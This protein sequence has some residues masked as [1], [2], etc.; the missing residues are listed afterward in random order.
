MNIK[1]GDLV[2]PIV[3]RFF[4]YDFRYGWHGRYKTWED[5]LKETTGYNAEAVLERVRE[6]ALKV[7][8]GEAVYERDAIIY[9]S[10]QV[11]FPLLSTLLW[12]ASQNNNRLSIIDYGGSLGTSYRQNYRFIKHLNHIE[13]KIIEQKVFVDEGRKNFENEHLSFYYD[14]KECLQ[15]FNEQPQ[16][17]MF[18]N[19]L[20]Y[21]QEPYTILNAVVNSGISN[22]L[23]DL[24]P[25][26][27]EPNDRLTIQ[28]VPPVFY[29]A[30]YPAWF[31]SRLKMY[32]FLGKYYE[33]VFDF[34]RGEKI[35]LSF[36]E[37]EYT[38][39][40]WTAKG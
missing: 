8:N 18:S 24:T 39:C 3:K 13:W 6:S 12:V 35:N 19:S 34:N 16:L 21:L 20:A 28:K 36:Q 23:L 25:F 2:P 37:V 27:D 7:K 26:I 11:Q 40:L 9:D 14:L 1:K 15:S 5:A 38:G 4:R 10:V 17:I 30:S 31:F 22:L 33:H 29:K 32:A